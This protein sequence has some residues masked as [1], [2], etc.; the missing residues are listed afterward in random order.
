MLNAANK[1]SLIE[2]ILSHIAQ[3]AHALGHIPAPMT[4]AEK[5]KYIK[6]CRPFFAVSDDGDKISVTY[7]EKELVKVG[8]VFNNFPGTIAANHTM[9][10]LQIGLTFTEPFA[11]RRIS[12]NAIN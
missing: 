7:N 1:T 6:A 3:G 11:G 2:I 4:N 5:A 9:G 12:I 8:P 10:G